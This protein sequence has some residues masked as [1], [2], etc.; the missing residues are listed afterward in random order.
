VVGR[1]VEQVILQGRV[2]QLQADVG[3][4]DIRL[5]DPTDMLNALDL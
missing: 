5:S 1:C 3:K 4:V 2:E